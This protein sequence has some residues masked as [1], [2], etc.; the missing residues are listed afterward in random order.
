MR[1]MRRAVDPDLLDGIVDAV[2]AALQRALDK[3]EPADASRIIRDAANRH[4]FGK[5]RRRP[6]ILPLVMT[7][8]S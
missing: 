3:S 8:E 2:T 7:V 6:V 5:T 1:A 4:V